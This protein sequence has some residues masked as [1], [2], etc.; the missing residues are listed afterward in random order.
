MNTK[1]FVAGVL[2]LIGGATVV[3]GVMRQGTVQPRKKKRP[4]ELPMTVIDPDT[5]FQEEIEKL[6]KWLPIK[7]LGNF[8]L[9]LKRFE[10]GLESLP[11]YVTKSLVRSLL[12]AVMAKNSLE[13]I[14]HFFP[15]GIAYDSILNCELDSLAVLTEGGDPEMAGKV[16][17]LYS[18]IK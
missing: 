16:T 2:G 4:P 3:K 17:L 11:E 7:D 18:Y 5:V 12:V 1:Y 13:R 10:G 14:S 6:K 9:V 15:D 8:E